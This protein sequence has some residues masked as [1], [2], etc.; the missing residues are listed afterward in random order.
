MLR[1]PVRVHGCTAAEGSGHIP[2]F[3]E[4]SCVQHLGLS[5]RLFPK[6]GKLPWWN[7][8]MGKMVMSARLMPHSLLP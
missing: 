2:R 8:W 1:S 5:R 7:E 6:H 3:G 4:A